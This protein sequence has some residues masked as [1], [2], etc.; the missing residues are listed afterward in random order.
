MLTR[1][2]IIEIKKTSEP[3]SDAH[4]TRWVISKALLA[5]LR[6]P[7]YAAKPLLVAKGLG[8]SE[9]VVA[10]ELNHLL[11]VGRIAC[12]EAG[13]YQIQAGKI[14]TLE[15]GP[16]EVRHRY[17]RQMLSVAGDKI[18]VDNAD[19]THFEAETFAFDP[20]MLPEARAIIDRCLKELTG[21]SSRC[22]KPSTVYHANISFFEFL[23]SDEP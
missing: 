1:G 2:Q 8:F 20:A 12:D 13:Q 14:E 22:S 4:P 19:R 18:R 7:M 11:K 5:S 15:E 23:E 17:Q 16:I 6:V 21:L 9:K 10:E 3:T